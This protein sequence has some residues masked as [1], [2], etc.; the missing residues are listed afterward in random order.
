MILEYIQSAL[1][2]GRPTTVSEVDPLPTDVRKVG[3]E[4]VD[5]TEP[6]KVTPHPTTGMATNQIALSVTAAQIVPASA[7]RRGLAVVANVDWYYGLTSGVTALT[8]M[9]CY[10]GVPVNFRGHVGAVY[11]ILASGTGIASYDERTD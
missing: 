2:L 4:D 5:N 8:G 9:L 3:G 1:G 11:G 10:A 6:A 7:T